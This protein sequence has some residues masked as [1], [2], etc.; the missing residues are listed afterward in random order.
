[1]KTSD[2]PK[3]VPGPYTLET[4]ASAPM[5]S[6]FKGESVAPFPGTAPYC[7]IDLDGCAPTE[8]MLDQAIA[9]T[10]LYVQ[11]SEPERDDEAAQSQ[12]KPDGSQYDDRDAALAYLA[13]GGALVKVPDFEESK[14]YRFLCVEESA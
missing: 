14:Y 6:A 8:A 5:F 11:R 3:F 2:S 9:E 12:R 4:L 1:M 10:R 7:L 13:S